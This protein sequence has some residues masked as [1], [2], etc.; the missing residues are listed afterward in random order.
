[1]ALM[2]PLLLA[3]LDLLGGHS[4]LARRLTTLALARQ[5][6]ETRMALRTSYLRLRR[7][8]HVSSEEPAWRYDDLA[9]ARQSLWT[10]M[11]LPDTIE[12]DLGAT[13]RPFPIKRIGSKCRAAQIEL[14]TRPKTKTRQT[15]PR[16]SRDQWRS[17][18]P[19]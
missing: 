18:C 3:A 9:L 16:S 19:A 13:Q 8:Q 14:R 10:R 11:A 4:G 12:I 1:M 15:Y 17:W 7:L 5:S 6:R 2:T